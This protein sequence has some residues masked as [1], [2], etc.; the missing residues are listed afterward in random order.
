MRDGRNLFWKEKHAH[1]ERW[2]RTGL[3]GYEWNRPAFCSMQISRIQ[4]MPEFLRQ[5][6]RYWL[7]GR[8]SGHSFELYRVSGSLFHGIV[9]FCLFH[10][11]LF[12]PHLPDHLSRR[13]LWIEA[14][15]SRI[16]VF[17]QEFGMGRSF[18]V[19]ICS[20]LSMWF[21]GCAWY[22]GAIHGITSAVW[23]KRQCVEEC[24]SFGVLR[25][26]IWPSYARTR[27]EARW[28]ATSGPSIWSELYGFGPWESDFLG[29]RQ[30]V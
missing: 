17:S 13:V 22:R 3:F 4:N 29:D 10:C 7:L 26:C 6:L 2:I 20:L 8:P 30:S 27:T 14:F 16:S 23:K 12:C 21:P 9:L 5:G 1:S 15:R 18:L 24:R 11:E 19:F 25:V 28:Q